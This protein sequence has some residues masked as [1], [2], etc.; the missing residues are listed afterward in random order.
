MHRPKK[1]TL[2]CILFLLLS[3]S[4]DAWAQS[5]HGKTET[6]FANTW[7]LGASIGPDFFYG[8]L[9]PQ[10]FGIDHNVSFAGSIFGGRQLTN[11]FGLRGQL[12]FAGLRGLKVK[13][14]NDVPVNQSFSGSLIE[15]NINTTINFSNLFSPYKPTRRFFVYGTLGVGFTNWNTKLTDLTTMQIIA[16]DSLPNWRS[17]A[18]IPFGLGAFYRI[19]ERINVGIE[20]TFR[21]AMSDYVDQRVTGF[22]YDFYDYLAIGV[23]FNLGK[24]RKRSPGIRE[25]PYPI[26]PAQSVT[27]APL[28]APLE[29]PQTIVSVTSPP[30]EEYVYV[31][32]IFAFARTAYKPET[33]RKRY[34]IAQPVKKEREGKLNRYIIGNY[35]NLEYAKELRDEMVKKGIHDAFIVA[36][37]NGQRDHVVPD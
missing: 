21:M 36:Y 12:L 18:V 20:W 26:S 16:A 33:I 9:S 23:T 24:L 4:H 7:I 8:D 34:H 17:A 37:K 10:G 25:Y 3:V 30:S 14:S 6:S 11:V 27:P 5:V 22:K 13:T 1:Y 19:S 2:F 31:V 28:M 15:F 32:Q 35:K 29:I